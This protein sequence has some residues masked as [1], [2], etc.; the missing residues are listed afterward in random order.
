MKKVHLNSSKI[1]RIYA[2]RQ[3]TLVKQGSEK[4]SEKVSKIF[5]TFVFKFCYKW[6]IEYSS[7]IV[8]RI[9]IEGKYLKS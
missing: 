4:I 6:K 5:G 9:P 3:W 1:L 8:Q 7:Q 2:K